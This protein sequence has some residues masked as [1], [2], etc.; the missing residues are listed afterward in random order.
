MTIGRSHGIHAEPITFG[1][2]L[3]V[4]LDIFE[5][6]LERFN[7]AAKDINVGQISGPVGTYSNVDPEIE[8]LSVLNL[9]LNLQEFLPRLSRGTYMPIICRL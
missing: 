2:K 1:L 5:R 4:W 9:G 3:G 7:K 6:N 8:K